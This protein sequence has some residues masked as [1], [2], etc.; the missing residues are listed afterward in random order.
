MNN[1]N[2]PDFESSIAAVWRF[3]KYD[4]VVMR[5]HYKYLPGD[6]VRLRIRLI[7]CG[8]E[9]CESQNESP[10]LQVQMKVT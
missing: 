8:D 6:I 4:D 7:L 9:W 2:S 3:Y 5:S 1:V 10:D